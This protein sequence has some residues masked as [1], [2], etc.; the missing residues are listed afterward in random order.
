MKILIVSLLR[1]GD[2]IQQ[3]ILIEGLR[4]KYPQ[5][6]I[7]LLVNAQFSQLKD[8]LG[9]K[10]DNILYFDRTALQKGL[11][12]AGYNMMWSYQKLDQL[13]QD[14]NQ[15]AYDQVI[16]FTHNKLS[17]YLIG[18]LSV[19]EKLGLHQVDGRF[20]GLDNPWIKYFNERFSGTS[21]CLF[22]YVELLAGSFQIP[23]PAPTVGVVPDKKNKKIYFQ[24]LTSEQR[25]NW[26]LDNFLNLKNEIN[27]SLAD[28]QVKI[29]AAPFEKSELLTKFSEEDLMVCNMI[30]AQD[31]LKSAA[32]LVTCDTSIKHLAA[33]LGVPMV[34][35]ALG[36]SDLQK[37]GAFA[38]NVVRLKGDTAAGEEITVDKVFA[39]VWDQLAQEKRPLKLD[40]NYLD[41]LIWRAHL[42]QQQTSL[43]D[44]VDL[45]GVIKTRSP[46]VLAAWQKKTEELSSV[47]LQFHQVLPTLAGL[48]TRTS[49]EAHE[50]SRIV[51]VAQNLVR[52]K[53]DS[54]GYFQRALE[55]LLGK[56]RDGQHFIEQMNTALQ[57][58]QELLLQRA[59][60]VTSLQ[61]L[62]Q[63]GNVYAKGFG[64]LSG[65]S[66]EE[67]RRKISGSIE[68]TDL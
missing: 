34:E 45:A 30:E 67:T 8:L 33:R 13:I 52:E 64:Q 1:L 66:F 40:Q 7:D 27:K 3:E 51:A 62:T 2:V 55:V 48:G 56:H 38:E 9:S 68:N 65:V 22:N 50:V 26:G 24:C 42:N 10:V 6:Q 16:N 59:E 23:I 35:L 37:T 17:A 11:G 25:K 20:A 57:E 43:T 5:A 58:T 31:I 44:L 39:A 29:L 46:G 54:S 15:R 61:A 21:Q 49:L 63:E 60:T 28:Y 41:R 12:E 4:K 18:T 14:L 47:L 32:L 19:P 53:I 36:G